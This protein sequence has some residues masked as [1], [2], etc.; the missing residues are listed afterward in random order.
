MKELHLHNYFVLLML[1]SLLFAL[2]ADSSINRENKTTHY[3]V[4]EEFTVYLPNIQPGLKNLV[5][6][7]IP[8]GTFEMG[9]PPS[10]PGHEENESPVHEVTLSKDFY[11]GKYE[12]TQA[13]W[14]ALMDENPSTE[15]GG[16]LPVNKVSWID[17][18]EFIKRLNQYS[19]QSNFRLPTEAEREYAARA[20]T[21]GISYLGD[22]HNRETMMEHAWFRNNSEGYLHP[23]GELKPNP[24]GLHDIFGNVWEWCHDWYVPAYPDEARINPSGPKS[25]VEKVFRGGSWMARFDYLRSADRGKFTPDNRRNTGGFRLAWSEVNIGD[26]EK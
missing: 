16:N 17:C 3:G 6:V 9:S 20:D 1:V 24:W 18:Q 21:T 14:L 25:G 13:Q 2:S 10:E 5:M 19:N 8:A 23:V 12:V 15:I 26:E 22:D 4:G 11:M 7:K